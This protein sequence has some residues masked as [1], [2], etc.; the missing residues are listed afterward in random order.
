MTEFGES[1]KN[2]PF[3]IILL[4]ALGAAI[5]GSMIY[6]GAK[7]K[8]EGVSCTLAGGPE[9]LCLKNQELREK[10]GI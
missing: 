9:N 10:N 7:N 4:S 8:V 1:I 3:T 6:F 2:K 5:L